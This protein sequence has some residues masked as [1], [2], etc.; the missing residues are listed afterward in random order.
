MFGTSNVFGHF[1]DSWSVGPSKNAICLRIF[2]ILI[3]LAIQ[4]LDFD[5]FLIVD[6]SGPPSFWLFSI[7]PDLFGNF[8]A[9]LGHK[10]SEN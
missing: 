9:I 6:N 4:F 10:I 7:I 2:R 5:I 1:Q 3:L 8:K